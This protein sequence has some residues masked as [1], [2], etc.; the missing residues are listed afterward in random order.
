METWYRDAKRLTDVSINRE[1]WDEILDSMSGEDLDL[2]CR[3]AILSVDLFGSL[4][5]KT[6]E[7]MTNTLTSPLDLVSASLTSFGFFKPSGVF[8]R[9]GRWGMSMSFFVVDHISEKEQAIQP[10]HLNLY[11][12]AEEQI[13][14]L[15]RT[16]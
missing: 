1:Q 7:A 2:D 12:G 8:N 10:F 16:P 5:V 15:N 13:S 4:P 11:R 14:W 3:M 6:M 9:D